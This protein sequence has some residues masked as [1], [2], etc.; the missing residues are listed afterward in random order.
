M[1]AD[2]RCSIKRI[3]FIVYPALQ[4]FASW[5]PYS[6]IV[7][8]NCIMMTFQWPANDPLWPQAVDISTA[9][10]LV[11]DMSD[12]ETSGSEYW[13]YCTLRQTALKFFRLLVQ[14]VMT[15]FVQFDIRPGSLSNGAK[16]SS[17]G[18]NLPT[19]TPQKVMNRGE[20]WSAERQNICL[21]LRGRG[22]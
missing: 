13:Y 1:S 16:N 5:L 9:D 8:V 17:W 15:S 21:S 10:G 4:A 20:S 14:T 19:G 18:A 3:M 22:K 12:A 7:V 6:A 2:T 11:A